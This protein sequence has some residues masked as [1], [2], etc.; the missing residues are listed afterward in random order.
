VIVFVGSNGHQPQLSTTRRQRS[1]V[2]LCQS[3]AFGCQLPRA[4]GSAGGVRAVRVRIDAVGAESAVSYLARLLKP[5]HGDSMPEPVLFQ[6]F[7]RI[8]IGRI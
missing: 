8:P 5:P 1:P 7:G 2:G 3:S 6:H 4:G